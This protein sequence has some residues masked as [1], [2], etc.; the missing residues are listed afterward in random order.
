MNQLGAT[1][2]G[3]R[4]NQLVAF[5]SLAG[6]DLGLDEFMVGDGRGELSNDRFANAAVPNGDYWFEFMRGGA[7]EL[8]LFACQGHVESPSMNEKERSILPQRANGFTVVASPFNSVKLEL[9]IILVAAVVLAL[10]VDRMASE[11]LTQMFVLGGLGV[12]AALWLFWRTRTISRRVRE[13]GNE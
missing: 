3:E 4:G 5:E 2:L 11:V 1:T 12:I 7:Q 6:A 13:K 10:V 9:G 8:L